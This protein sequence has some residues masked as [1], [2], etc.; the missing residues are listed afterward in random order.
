MVTAVSML[1]AVPAEILG[2]PKGKIEAGLDADLTIF[3]SDFQVS[4]VFVSGIH[5]EV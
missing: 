4:D 1:T 2:L 5:R 3:D